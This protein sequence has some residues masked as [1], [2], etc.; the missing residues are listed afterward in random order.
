MAASTVISGP[1]PSAR[2][3]RVGFG[4]AFQGTLALDWNNGLAVT[5]GVS[6][7]Q[8]A[9]VDANNDRIVMASVGGAST[10]IGGWIAVGTN[11]TASAGAG[12][13][14]ISQ[15]SPPVPVYVPAGMRV[16]GLQGAAAGTLSLIPALIASA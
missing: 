6:S 10:V 9:V 12:S 14:W 13:M 8:S 2:T 11:P 5:L 3:A 15:T 1:R 7:V 4:D 16:A